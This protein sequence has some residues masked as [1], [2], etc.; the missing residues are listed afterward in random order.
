MHGVDDQHLLNLGQRVLLA[1]EEARD[2]PGHMA[3]AVEGR[4]RQAPHEPLA[5]AA[6]DEAHPL[7][8]ERLAQ[9]FRRLAEP[10]IGAVARTAIDADV[11]NRTHSIDLPLSIKRRQAG[12][13]RM[14]AELGACSRHAHNYYQARTLEQTM[15]SADLGDQ[16]E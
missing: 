6:I 3:A 2:H 9:R 7:G 13:R 16:L 12:P 11:P 14:G 15:I 4:A 10:L 1:D 8:C 5:A